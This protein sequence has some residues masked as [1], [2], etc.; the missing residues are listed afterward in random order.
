VMIRHTSKPGLPYWSLPRPAIGLKI[1]V[2]YNALID[3]QTA[4]APK[5]GASLEGGE[6]REKRINPVELPGI[7]PGSFRLMMSTLPE[8]SLSAP[9]FQQPSPQLCDN[10]TQRIRYTRLNAAYLAVGII[11]CGANQ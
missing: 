1:W 10:H 6:E 8:A 3:T 7:E 11:V 4:E 5:S 2:S 9:L